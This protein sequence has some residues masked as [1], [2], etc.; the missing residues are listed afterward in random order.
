[1]I[2]GKDFTTCE[3]LKLL[4]SL[5]EETTLWDLHLESGTISK[6][7]EESWESGL[8]MNGDEVE[9]IVEASKDLTLPIVATQVRASWC[10][11]MGG[12]LHSGGELGLPKTQSHTKH[13]THSHA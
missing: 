13:L 3:N 9:I 12:I 1:M 5:E 2:T 10:K 11:E 7:N 8:P 4:T 6:P